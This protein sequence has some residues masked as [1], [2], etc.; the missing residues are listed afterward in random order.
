MIIKSIRGWFGRPS[1]A[2]VVTER[3]NHHTREL[4]EAQRQLEHAKANVTYHQNTLRTLQQTKHD[5]EKVD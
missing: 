4:I 5:L 3:T 1:P 2:A